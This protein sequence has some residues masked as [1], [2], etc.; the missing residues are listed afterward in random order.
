M[1]TSLTCFV[2][3]ANTNGRK[4]SSVF[5]SSIKMTF[6]SVESRRERGNENV[7]NYIKDEYVF[8]ICYTISRSFLETS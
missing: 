6:S 8:T 4:A 2:S 5:A 1:V 7:V 3:Q